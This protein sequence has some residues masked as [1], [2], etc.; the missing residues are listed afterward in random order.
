MRSHPA[1]R[2][3]AAALAW[4]GLLAAALP[5]AAQEAPKQDPCLSCH[6]DP[7]KVKSPVD[8]ALFAKSVHG[9][10]DG[11]AKCH[12]NYDEFPH[13][14]DKETAGCAD[15]HEAEAEGFAKS[16]H[17]KEPAPGSKPS[18]APTCADCHGVHDVFRK[19]ERESSL[20]P[21]NVP[22]T[23]GKCHFSSP[24]AAAGPVEAMLR[25][26]FV[27]DTHGSGLL[28]SGLVVSPSCIDCHGGHDILATEDKRAA[29]NPARVAETCGKCHVGVLE[30]YRKSIHGKI[31]R[32]RTETGEAA[33]EPAT[34]T[35]CHRP[36]HVRKPDASFRIS[37]VETCTKCHG[38]RG[39]TYRGTFHGRMTDLGNGEVA[40]CADCHTAHSMLP[41]GDPASSVHPSN[42]RATCAK[43]HEGAGEEFARYSVHA[44]PH[45]LGKY[46][47]LYWF[48]FAMRWILHV[49]WI[50]G[51]I[52]MLLWLQ[53]GLRDGAVLRKTENPTGRWYERWRPTYRYLHLTLMIS[54]TLLAGTGL[55][56]L[57]HED[58]WAKTVYA[59]L[60]GAD[61]MRVLHRIGGAM[62]VGYF[63]AYFIHITRRFLS[64]EKGLFHGS[65]T[66]LP[67][68][69]DLVDL[70]AHVKWFVAGGEQPRFDRWAYW[71]KFY[72]LAELW[73][74]G[75]MGVTGIIM[76]FPVAATT[77]LPGEALNIAH[78]VHSHE[79]LLATSVIF[80][81][82]SFHMNLRP[83]K[84]P[85]DPVVF[86]GRISEEDLRSEHPLEYERMKSDGRLE[87]DALPPPDAASLRRAHRIG[88]VMLSLAFLLLVF[89]VSTLF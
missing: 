57:F 29:V 55:P 74:V 53:R 18:K 64:G 23:C 76:W 51:G 69:K 63:S 59:A 89:M 56:M 46:P 81:L 21:L 79:A 70:L 16:V 47:L 2:R 12:F 14:G 11:C 24:E 28:K 41:A 88:G 13:G 75:V 73:G 85:M 35:D 52:H 61:V 1:V 37:T 32:G 68:P 17:G 27:D 82:H 87:R 30:L 65:N 6:A 86:T 7:A 10:R 15:C 50:F 22:R 34:C 48:E 43:C 26:Q 83:G 8:G 60:G 36:H 9:G 19:K 40:T 44:S 71:H 58:P 5:A 84:F 25:E 3:A 78:V 38:E 20:F 31:P 66:M 4:L 39:E 77:V 45:D 42:V 80:V 33:V 62:T 49:T 67:R 54:F 72:F